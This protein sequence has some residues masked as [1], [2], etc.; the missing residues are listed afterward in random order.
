MP[1]QTSRCA[2]FFG[3]QAVAQNDGRNFGTLKRGKVFWKFLQARHAAHAFEDIEQL[4]AIVAADSLHLAMHPAI[5]PAGNIGT[6]LAL[7]TFV[8]ISLAHSADNFAAA[9]KNSSRQMWI[10]RRFRLASSAG[11][12][13]TF[14]MIK[15]KGV[16]RSPPQ[17]PLATGQVWRMEGANLEIGM[18]GRLLVHYKLGK[19]NAV[20]VANSCSAIKTIEKYLKT[21]KAKLV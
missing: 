19:P 18:V 15:K 14:S 10:G 8:M 2:G 21:N 17:P 12:A 6:I 9:K 3:E 16:R 20:R 5:S 13:Q 4:A 1:F 11:N 7:R